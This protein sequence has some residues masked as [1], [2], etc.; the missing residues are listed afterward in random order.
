MSAIKGIVFDKDG[1]LLDFAA[2]WLPAFRE[3]AAAVAGD[4][5]DTIARLLLLGGYDPASGTVAAGSL[6]AA[7]SNGEIA[8]AWATELP[9]TGVEALAWRL[10]RIFADIGARYAA[11]VAGAEA[12]LAR[13]KAG[14]L[15][16]GVATSDSEAG[17]RA[18]LGPSGILA[19]LDFLA[20]YDSGHG[21]KP[22]PGMVQGFCRHVGLRPVEVAVVGDNRHDLEMGRRAGA[23]LVVG[24]LTG[25][26]SRADLSEQADHVFDSLL[27]L[28]DL[29]FGG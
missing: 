9:G 2:T 5:E 25:T 17:A 26:G 6:F 7:G 1:T 19:Q 21:I 22:G 13:L 11:P 3:A 20:G 15:K 29:L 24:V 14:G 23:G 28:E 10:D 16:L 4:A 18:T 8:A 27:G 12:F